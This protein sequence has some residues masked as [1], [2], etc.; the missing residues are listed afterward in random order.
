M[1]A[2][3]RKLNWPVFRDL[4]SGEQPPGRLYRGQASTAWRL[5]PSLFRLDSRPKLE[6]YLAEMVPSVHD[7]I[8]GSLD[9]TLNL[10]LPRDLSRFLAIL[11]RYEFPT[12]LLDWTRSPL[13][14]A[15]FAFDHALAT[16]SGHVA[17][18]QLDVTA[19]ALATLPIEIVTPHPSDN[20]TL[21][22]QDGMHLRF[23]TE[24][25]LD[26]EST[27]FDGAAPEPLVRFDLP[28][29]AALVA[30]ADLENLGIHAGSLFPG[31][32]KVCQST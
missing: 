24:S 4:V 5:Q 13:I 8:S 26:V 25:P 6:R 23:L 9:F 1:M 17:I 7:A 11:R 32:C 18:W 31:G 16:A 12:P 2:S 14:A 22:A 10:S 15:F 28:A 3:P 21:L 19:G 20:P 27:S 29:S 30:L